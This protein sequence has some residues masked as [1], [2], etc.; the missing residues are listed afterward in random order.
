MMEQCYIKDAERRDQ[1]RLNAGIIQ[2]AHTV[3]LSP[4]LIRTRYFFTSF[5][6]NE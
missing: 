5:I 6:L 4:W 1:R 2:E 3:T